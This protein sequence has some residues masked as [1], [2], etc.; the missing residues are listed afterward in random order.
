MSQPAA[1]RLANITAESE[2]CG[3]LSVKVVFPQPSNP[4]QAA[5]RH[6]PILQTALTRG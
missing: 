4:D 6:Q 3:G 5:R 1:G 2:L